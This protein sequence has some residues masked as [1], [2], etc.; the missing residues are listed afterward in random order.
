MLLELR[1]VA[2]EVSGRD[3]FAG[4]TGRLDAGQ[5]IALTGPNG[6]G[7][8]TL[9]R[10]IAG[11]IEPAAG[12]V[13]VSRG[14]RVG[15]LRQELDVD[16]TVTL[17][18][19]ALGAGDGEIA[20][21]ERRLRRLEAEL[22]EDESRLSAY[23][24][25]LTT[26]EQ[27][28]GYLWENRVRGTLRG[29]GFTP[30][31]ESMPAAG[32]SGGQKVRLALARLLLEAPDILLLDEPT[33]H[34]DLPAMAWLEETLRQY[35]GGIIAAS[36]DRAFL[37]N[38]ASAIWDFSPLGFQVF[39]GGYDAYRLHLKG[40]L[41][42][43]EEESRRV[44]EERERLQAYIRRYKA[45][46]RSTQAHD[47][48]RKLERLGPAASMRRAGKLKLSF[49][50]RPL[51][52]R[53][54]FLQVRGLTH[55]YPGRK[56]WQ[57][58]EFSLAEG[59]RLGIVGRNGSGKTTLLEAMRGTFKPD[60]GEVV[61]APGTRLGY[62]AQEVSVQGESPLDALLRL[63]GMTVFAARRLLARHL[64]QPQQ[65]ETPLDKLSGG[66]RSRLALAVLVAQ[67]ANVLLL[68]EPTNHLD[69]PAQE[70]LEEALLAFHG[71]LLLISHDRAL[72]QRVTDR[73]LWLH[74]DG[75]WQITADFEELLGLTETAPE[76]PAV[77]RDTRPAPA[78]QR[79]ARRSQLR[80][81]VAERERLISEAEETRK[82]VEAELQT[83]SGAGAAELATRLYELTQEIE[84]LYAAWQTAQEA[85]EAEAAE[86]LRN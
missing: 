25:A 57:D 68:D 49:D 55:A 54:L 62:L 73:W 36:H 27:L 18:Q 71:T 3:L 53:T 65:L 1:D 60:G 75:R 7:K 11:L 69:L 32:L 15:Y 21:L 5:R 41:A 9:L 44:E 56:L 42:R 37:R 39:G 10:I 23:G 63:P 48:E 59:G 82:A 76:R 26:Y 17:W 61:W 31:Q 50:A 40:Q 2:A 46:N 86:E 20:K 38:V 84:R 74:G 13:R 14:A 64:F 16:G 67:G 19:Y 72:L 28:G 81:E 43:Q 58:L 33:N 8:T 51:G 24:Q 22:A 47:R 70:A 29:L 34:L 30:E 78:R 52:E 80:A 4:V 66:E 45:G 77:A 35:P 12:D 6:I 79:R 83:A 85:L